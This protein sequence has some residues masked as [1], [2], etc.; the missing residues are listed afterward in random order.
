MWSTSPL[1]RACA[2][3]NAAGGRVATARRAA[4]HTGPARPRLLPTPP[5]VPVAAGPVWPES[6]MQGK[7]GPS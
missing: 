6:P 4:A 2:Q 3:S 7:G 5:A 1:T